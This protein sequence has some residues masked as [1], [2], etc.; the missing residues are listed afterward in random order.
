MTVNEKTHLSHWEAAWSGHVRPKIPSPLNIG[1]RNIF[2]LLLPYMNSGS[3]YVEIGCAPGKLLAWAGRELNQPVF[4]IDYSPK[5]VDSAKALCKALNVAAEIHCENALENTLEKSSFNLVFS[6]GLIEHFDDPWPMIK[7]HID[8]LAPGG[9]AIIGIPNYSGL[10]L[11]LQRF[12][13]KSNLRLHNLN[14][15]HPKHLYDTVPVSKNY[16]ISTSYSGRFS[17]WLISF[18]R[19]FGVFGFLM[20][21]VL[22]FAA[23]LQPYSISFLSPLIVLKITKNSESTYTTFLTS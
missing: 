14:I 17:P 1:I 6:C 16:T 10:Y 22:N 20:S 15:M 19:K 2:D 21:W 4:G 23:H 9:T 7:A 8:L 13:D 5:G 12:F 11:W 3:R 18:Q